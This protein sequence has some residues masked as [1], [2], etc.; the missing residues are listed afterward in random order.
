MRFAHPQASTCA[1]AGQRY[2]CRQRAGSREEDKGVARPW[3]VV[4][5]AES[6][7]AFFLIGTS[8]CPYPSVCP[9]AD[10]YLSIKTA[11]CVGHFLMDSQNNYCIYVYMIRSDLLLTSAYEP[12]SKFRMLQKNNVYN[13]GGED[14]AD[15]QLRS[16]RPG[17]AGDPGNLLDGLGGLGGVFPRLLHMRI[18]VLCRCFPLADLMLQPR[19]VS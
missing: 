18:L 6:F 1:G 9:S 5:H 13:F 14:G 10:R 12:L 4:H 2:V 7:Q 11:T 3:A 15:G 16:S 19:A 8:K 17:G